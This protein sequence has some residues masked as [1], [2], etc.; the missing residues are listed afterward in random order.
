MKLAHNVQA[1]GLVRS[2]LGGMALVWLASGCGSAASDPEALVELGQELHGGHGHRRHHPEASD[3]GPICSTFLNQDQLFQLVNAD[4]AARD[5]EDRP[6]QR[7][8]TIANRLGQLGCGAGLE[9]ERAALAKALNSVSIDARARG[10]VP[11]D[12]DQELFRIDLRDYQWDRQIVI[13]GTRFRDAWEA[14]LAQSPYALEY[15]GDDADDAKADTGTTVPLLFSNALLAAVARAPVYYA[16]LDIPAD[17]DD[18]LRDALG[19]DRASGE[20]ARAGFS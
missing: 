17:V 20:T 18:F 2:V 15:V 13:D 7:Y 8:V 5:A 3:R 14:L 16:L 4:L 9:G 11:V 1:R 12:A 6:F 19:I 10:L